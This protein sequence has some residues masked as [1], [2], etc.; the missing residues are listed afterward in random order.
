MRSCKSSSINVPEISPRLIPRIFLRILLRIPLGFLQR[1]LP[2]NFLKVSSKN[3]MKNH[4]YIFSGI[5]LKTTLVIP[6]DISTEKLPGYSFRNSYKKSF[7]NS[8]E[9]SYEKKTFKLFLGK[10]SGDSAGH[11]FEDAQEFLRGFL[12]NFIQ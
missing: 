1:I 9:H 11:S 5:S 7:N 12:Q 2:E 6:S 10:L 3:I 8:S 4:Y